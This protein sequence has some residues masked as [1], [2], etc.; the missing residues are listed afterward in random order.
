[1]RMSL[2]E[3]PEWLAFSYMEETGSLPVI[4]INSGIKSRSR[5]GFA[6]SEREGPVRRLLTPEFHS[7]K[8]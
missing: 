2:V 4:T 3:R 6:P 5:G 1:M 8:G 7:C